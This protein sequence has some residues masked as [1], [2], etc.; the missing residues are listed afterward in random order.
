LTF[1]KVLKTKNGFVS[2]VCLH[3]IF[4]ETAGN[5]V[6]SKKFEAKFDKYKL[7]KAIRYCGE[8][9]LQITAE[10][11]IHKLLEKLETCELINI[12]YKLE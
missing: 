6:N 4:I 11:Y 1:D 12:G 7:H 10:S 2:E 8:D 5:V 3:P 9:A